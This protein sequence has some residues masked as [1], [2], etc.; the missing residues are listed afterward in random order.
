MDELNLHNSSIRRLLKHLD[1]RV[2]YFQ[3]QIKTCFHA[4]MEGD[5]LNVQNHV[6]T[7]WI[8]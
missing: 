7:W 8:C 2:I 6:R 5:N 1:Y 3:F 4:K